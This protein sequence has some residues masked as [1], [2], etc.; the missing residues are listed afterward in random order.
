MQKL[1]KIH[2]KY[3]HSKSRMLIVQNQRRAN[4]IFHAFFIQIYLKFMQIFHIL[5]KKFPKLYKWPNFFS[6]KKSESMHNL[7]KSY[8]ES[9]T[10]TIKMHECYVQETGSLKAGYIN[11][12]HPLS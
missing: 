3:M 12:T 9:I 5:C 6:A 1:Y 4:G 8:K 10:Q 7:W 11:G 2:A